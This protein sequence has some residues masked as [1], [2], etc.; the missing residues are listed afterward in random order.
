M[1]PSH[2][3]GI[4]GFHPHDELSSPE[5]SASRVR[6]KSLPTQGNNHPVA[7]GDGFGEW[8]EP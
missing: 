8:F 1:L 7:I 6:E 2:T 4:G 3:L 5:H